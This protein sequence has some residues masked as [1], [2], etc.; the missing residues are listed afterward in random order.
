[1]GLGVE[2]VE[3]DEE[4][5]GPAPAPIVPRLL[6]Q[7]GELPGRVDGPV[8]VLE[9][10]LEMRHRPFPI[11]RLQGDGGQRHMGAAVAGGH[12][13]EGRRLLERG[14]RRLGVAVRPQRV[15]QR[16][17][18]GEALRMLL[19]QLAQVLDPGLALQLPARLLGARNDRLRVRRIAAQPAREHPVPLL[20]VLHRPAQRA[21]PHVEEGVERRLQRV[22]V[23]PHPARAASVSRPSP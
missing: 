13:R 8:V 3:L 17:V 5:V 10:G 2:R 20:R 15:A 18:D 12:R 16:H 22:E 11:L 6:G 14:P 9:M 19:A 23:E 4:L 1:M 7:G 21:E